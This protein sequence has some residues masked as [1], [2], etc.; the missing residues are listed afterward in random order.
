MK[1][2]HD[3]T[4]EDAFIPLARRKDMR[5]PPRNFQELAELERSGSAPKYLIANGHVYR[6]INW[7]GK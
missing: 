7:R 5:K 6:L 1:S 2:I 4:R 3:K